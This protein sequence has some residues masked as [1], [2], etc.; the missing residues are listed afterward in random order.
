M[1]TITL[2]RTVRVT[3]TGTDLI[4]FRKI[5]PLQGS[6]KIREQSDIEKIIKS[7]I[8]HGFSFP[9]FIWKE[10]GKNHALDGH[11]RLQALADMKKAAYCLDGKKQLFVDEG[12]GW[13]VPLLPFVNIEA[14][15][16][17]EA[18]EKLLKLNSQYGMI[19][20]ASFKLFT[21]GLKALDLSGI[22]IKFEKIEIKPPSL[23][24]PETG[25]A[26][27]YQPN[28]NPD[29]AAGEVSEME[30]D[31]ANEK[32]ETAMLHKGD[33]QT[34]ELCCPGCGE[35]FKISVTDALVLIE[36]ARK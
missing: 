17:D 16:M 25:N 20:D 27:A 22:S 10:G 30:L 2:D 35:T 36:E 28:L 11:G 9:F 13:K 14:E 6:L 3:C 1:D 24:D 33:V 23:P 15:N 4:D 8:L 19:T 5:R 29:I 32:L 26:K 21:H 18:K 34:V 31:R 7:I 12:P